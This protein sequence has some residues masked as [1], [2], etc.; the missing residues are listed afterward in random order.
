MESN[1]KPQSLQILLAVA[2]GNHHGYAIRQ[3]VESRTEGRVRLWPATLYGTLADLT[4]AELLE[5]V[6]AV[7]RGE[8]MQDARRRNYRLTAFGKRVLEAE[9]RRLEE[10]VRYAR[11]GRVLGEA[12]RSGR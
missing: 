5:E 6:G 9:T 3:E 12:R 2:G 8:A 10:L 1:L 7:A 4:R 11:S